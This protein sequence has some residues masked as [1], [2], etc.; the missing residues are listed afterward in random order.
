VVS[1]ERKNVVVFE[2]TCTATFVQN[3]RHYERLNAE[4]KNTQEIQILATRYRP[5]HPFKLLVEL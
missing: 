1:N 4:K 5:F 3:E 2:K